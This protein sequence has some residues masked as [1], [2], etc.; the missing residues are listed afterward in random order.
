MVLSGYTRALLAFKTN[1]ECPT[2]EVRSCQGLAGPNHP[3]S[4]RNVP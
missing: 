1:A 4:T 2:G 3:Y